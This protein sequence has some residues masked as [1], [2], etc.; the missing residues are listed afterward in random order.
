MAT[1]AKRRRDRGDRTGTDTDEETLSSIAGLSALSCL[2]KVNH[3]SVQELGV[4]KCM[5]ERRG[6]GE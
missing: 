6:G 3:L 1:A 4:R 5:R 2:G